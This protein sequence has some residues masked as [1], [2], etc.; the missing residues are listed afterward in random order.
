M[1]G[2]PLQFHVGLGDGLSVNHLGARS[3]AFIGRTL[4]LASRSASCSPNRNSTRSVSRVAPVS[5][6]RCAASL[7]SGSAGSDRSPRN[8]PR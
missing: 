1:A 8:P 7:T 4:E 3:A 6:H 5:R 2:K